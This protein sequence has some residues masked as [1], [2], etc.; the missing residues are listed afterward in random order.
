MPVNTSLHPDYS[1]MLPTVT[2]VRDAVEGDPA[3]KWR[4]EHYLPASFAKKDGEYTPHYKEYLAR[5][6]FM[7]VTGRTK[8]ALVGMVFRKAPTHEMP[9]PLENLLEDI[10]GSGQSLDQIA[11]EMIG[12][13][14]EAGKQYLLVDYPEAEEG[15]DSE[16][17]QR[18]GLR[19]TIAAYPF[20]SLIN[21]RFE[22]IKGRQMLTMAVLR[23]SVDTGTDEF[24]HDTDYRYRVLRLRD[25]VYTQQ[26]YDEGGV[27]IT[28]EYSPRMAG[29]A[30][31]DHIPLHI[32]GAKSNLPGKDMPPLY[33]IARVNIGHYQNTANTEESGY[34][35]TQPMLH[36]D[37]GETSL[38]E[39]KQ[40]NADPLAFGNRQ[41][42]TTKGGR[43]DIV[44]AQATDYNLTLMERKEGQMVMLGARLVQRGGQAETAEASRIN[45]SAEASVLDV[46]V[47]NAS[48]AIEAALED[49]A[50]FMGID[51]N[52]V[53]YQLNKS[54]W[55]SSL[56][57]QDLVAV[58]QGYQGGVYGSKDVIYMMRKGSIT[59]DPDRDDEE[60]M[61]DAAS[62]MLD[63]LQPDM[64]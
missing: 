59:L 6:Y 53:S 42:L 62:G 35:G 18:L 46:L 34:I 16:T 9:T 50:R 3:I 52:A 17:E 40:H 60:I 57:G 45:A 1:Y 24:G 25:G 47:G 14:M 15:M 48:E 41:G 54:F 33:D 23:E 32:A 22:G 37:V 43:L 64:Q 5:A 61:Q 28:D 19:P 56:S 63:S 44:Q 38:E 2:M 26:V 7:G 39:W 12:E 11:K 30:P 29:G 49:M 55:E 31:F 20:E 36:V 58:M 8:E 21:W 51:P 13:L 4:K 10:D 27:S